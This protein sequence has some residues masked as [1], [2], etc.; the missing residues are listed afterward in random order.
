MNPNTSVT[1]QFDCNRGHELHTMCIDVGR[2]V[3]PELRC[4]E[5]Q[6]SG[7]VRQGGGCPVPADL[8]E[9]VIR[10]LRD[11]FQESKRRG[12]VLIRA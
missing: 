11:N 3:P 1:V 7:I 9:R 6:P 2:G 8:R 5:G 12:Y 4:P 10:E